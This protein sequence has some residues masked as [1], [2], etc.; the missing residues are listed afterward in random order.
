MRDV[1]RRGKSIGVLSFLLFSVPYTVFGAGLFPTIVPQEGSACYCN[2][3]APSWGCVLEVLQNVINVA[4]SL[5]IVFCVFWIAYAGFSMMVSGGVAEARSLGK[6]RLLNAVVGIC[7]ILA[8]WLV[9]DFVMK[10][11]YD[12][13]AAFDASVIGPWNSILASVKDDKCIVVTTPTGLTGGWTDILGGVPDG[14]SNP[15]GGGG[16]GGDIGVAKGICA[17]SNTSCSVEVMKKEGLSEAQAKAMSCIAVTESSGN[18]GIGYSPTGACGLFQITTRPGNWSI[19]KYHKSPC[20]SSTSCHNA[21][22]NR[23]TAVLMFKD[24]GY[25]PWTG[26]DPKTGKHWNP[27]AVACVA[28]YDPR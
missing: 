23:Q 22:C 18:P 11:V 6:T 27:N 15:G 7:V 13:T 10:A 14:T 1:L 16:G 28:K 2:G 4:V 19:A 3:L 9:V 21:A 12:P 20:S 24:S 17:D 25:Q 5:G 26:K 8:S